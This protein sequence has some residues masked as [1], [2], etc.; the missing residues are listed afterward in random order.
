M[1]PRPFRPISVRLN[2]RR[3]VNSERLIREGLAASVTDTI[4]QITGRLPR[5]VE[6]YLRARL[7]ATTAGRQ[8][9]G[10][11]DMALT[12]PL[13]EGPEPERS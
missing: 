6:D 11:K 2:R 13:P 4:H 5:G 12:V 10:R 9:R 1:P 3:S 7:A 8:F